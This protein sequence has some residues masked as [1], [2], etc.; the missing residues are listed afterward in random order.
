MLGDFRI[1]AFPPYITVPI[2]L[3]INLKQIERDG[4]SGCFW[5]IGLKVIFCF[6]PLVFSYSLHSFLHTYSTMNI[7]F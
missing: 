2:S 6:V 1:G 7:H 3:S 4:N 5:V